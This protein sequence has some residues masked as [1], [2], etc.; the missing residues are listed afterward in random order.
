MQTSF[1][2]RARPAPAGRGP[3]ALGIGVALAALGTVATGCGVLPTPTADPTARGAGMDGGMDAG[4]GAGGPGGAAPRARLRVSRA[5]DP[6]PAVGDLVAA[7][8]QLRE[9]RSTTIQVGPDVGLDG[10][11][12]GADALVAALADAGYGIQRVAA[13]QGANF[14]D[15]SFGPAPARPPADVPVD[16][17]AGG[18]PV[19]LTGIASASGANSDP[20]PSSG[21]SAGSGAASR[22][23]LA[24]GAL[25]L[26][27][28]YARA[29]RGLV[30]V[31]PLELGGTRT[32]VALDDATRLPGTAPGSSGVVFAAAAPSFGPAP[33]ISLVTDDVVRG[34]TARATRGRGGSRPG[35]RPA[36]TRR[37][38][39]SARVEV[40]NL[41]F[42]ASAFDALRTEREAV[43]TDTIVFGDDS[44][45]LGP[46][47]KRQVARFVDGYDPASDMI[48]LVGCSNGPTRLAIGNEGLALGRSAR[49][50]EELVALGVERSR[51][52]DEGCWAGSSADGRFPSRG[53]LIEL[54]REPS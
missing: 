31:S 12:P 6:G 3:R 22:A 11:A 8:V 43:A 46:D 35:A 25:T 42:G 1:G 34:V 21:S 15:W 38:I 45:R 18:P 7:L 14:L 26:E 13:D 49:V 16:A 17:P 51:I 48:A 19:A 32:G 30:A 2:A 39:N 27:R 5:V 41:F 28:D 47:G 20:G 24:V 9:P 33:I 4:M 44:M 37:G 40:N 10:G 52:L 23:R 54:L 36:T 50:T 53:V 29:G